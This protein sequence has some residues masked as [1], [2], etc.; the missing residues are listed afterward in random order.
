MAGE[1]RDAFTV[2]SE[3]W[4][5]A[6]PMRVGPKSLKGASGWD[7]AFG[8]DGEARLVEGGG[9]LHLVERFDIQ[10]QDDVGGWVVGDRM[11]GEPKY[12]VH[13]GAGGTRVEAG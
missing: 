8:V 12:F 9:G 10:S 11:L 5:G 6:N 2:R 7:R 4:V 1:A 3:A 13:G